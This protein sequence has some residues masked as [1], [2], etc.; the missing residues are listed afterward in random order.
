VRRGA[1]GGARVR[2]PDG[3]VAAR[4]AGFVL[5][6]RGT[7]LSDVYEA[8]NLIEAPAA[9]LVAERR[10]E[11]DLERLCSATAAERAAVE[12]D[13]GVVASLQ[14]EFHLLLV[15]LTQNKTLTVVSRML[16]TI[17]QAATGNVVTREAG[18]HRHHQ[19][20]MT[21]LGTSAHER[22]VRLIEARDSEGA[23]ALWRSH[24]VEGS[25]YILEGIADQS[26]VDVL[27]HP[28]P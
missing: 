8:R 1:L 19:V 7:T 11:E 13:Q 4:Y 15:E 14:T 12:G 20:K 21:K 16:H 6:Y 25:R 18:T 28:L 27:N 23:E 10:T 24:L 26:I 22:L 2:V 5:Q 17:I 3:D 9:A